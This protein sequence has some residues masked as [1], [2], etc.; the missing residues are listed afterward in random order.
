MKVEAR[1][2]NIDNILKKG[3]YTIP[4]YQRDYDW[5]VDNVEELVEDILK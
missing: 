4:E 1:N 5:S 2:I 3:K